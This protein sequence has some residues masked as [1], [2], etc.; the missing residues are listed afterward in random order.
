M[1]G[2]NK[3]GKDKCFCKWLAGILFSKIGSGGLF[4]LLLLRVFFKIGYAV[5]MKSC[6]L[7]RRFVYRYIFIYILYMLN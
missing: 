3:Q 5:D 4:F 6:I 7:Q 2:K 1:P